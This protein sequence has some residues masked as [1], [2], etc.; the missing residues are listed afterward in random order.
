[1]GPTMSAPRGT[2]AV[3]RCRCGGGLVA[4]RRIG[5]LRGQVT[6]TLCCFTCGYEEPSL[7]GRSTSERNR[8]S[9]YY[10]ST[11]RRGGAPQTGAPRWR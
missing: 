5:P 8:S 6:P 9:S 11:R 7:Y 4:A 1:M 2:S 3:R 10:T